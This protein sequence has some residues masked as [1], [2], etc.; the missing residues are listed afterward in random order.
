MLRWHHEK[1]NHGTSSPVKCMSSRHVPCRCDAALR[2][3]FQAAY[4][5]RQLICGGRLES[6]FANQTHA[7]IQ[8]VPTPRL[9]LKA[10]YAFLQ[11]RGMGEGTS[12]TTHTNFEES[13]KPA[14][15][16]CS[17]A[18]ALQGSREAGLSNFESAC[19]CAQAC[20]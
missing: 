9:Q 17:K 4:P 8:N 12:L 15:L 11:P 2:L 14:R 7:Q 19:G 5:L 16:I 6:V 18:T 13:G 3:L 1:A 20:H 10:S